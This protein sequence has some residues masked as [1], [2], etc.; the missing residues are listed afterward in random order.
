MT[1]VAPETLQL[2]LELEPALMVEG[3]ARKLAMT[4]GVTGGV[5]EVV[6][7]LPLQPMA[8]SDARLAM[9]KRAKRGRIR[10]AGI[11]CSKCEQRIDGE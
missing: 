9:E 6:E 2:K 7:P 10:C 11:I 3:E 1:E 8:R 4:G 5:D